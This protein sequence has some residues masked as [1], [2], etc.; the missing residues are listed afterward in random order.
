MDDPQEQFMLISLKNKACIAKIS[1]KT[2]P[3]RLARVVCRTLKCLPHAALTYI[4]DHG[5]AKSAQWETALALA[6]RSDGGKVVS[7]SLLPAELHRGRI[8]L[9]Q[10][11]YLLFAT[12]WAICAMLTFIGTRITWQIPH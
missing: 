12:L 8:G 10:T 6:R 1:R 5:V 7:F 4:D 3:Y 11:K 2:T 9:H